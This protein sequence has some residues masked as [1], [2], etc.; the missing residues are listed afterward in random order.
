MF[1]DTILLLKFSLPG[2][3]VIEMSLVRYLSAHSI[4][5]PLCQPVGH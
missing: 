2:I 5:S 1:L 3:P 4:C